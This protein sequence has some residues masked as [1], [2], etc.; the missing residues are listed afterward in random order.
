MTRKRTSTSAVFLNIGSSGDSAWW[1]GLRNR[2]ESAVTA[3]TFGVE[4]SRSELTAAISRF[5]RTRRDCSFAELEYEFPDDFNR[6]DDDGRAV[7]FGMLDQ[8][9]VFWAGLSD[10]MASTLIQMN[11]ESRLHFW[12]THFIVYFADGRVPNLPLAKNIPTAGYKQERWLPVVIKPGPFPAR[13]KGKPQQKVRRGSV[14][15][16]LPASLR[17]QIFE[18]D[19]EQC[20]YC[21]SLTGPFEIDH[22]HPVSRGGTNTPS[23]LVVACRECNRSKR[24]KLVDE[25]LQPATIEEDCS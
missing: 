17:A 23:N 2:E 1:A 15:Q 20:Q 8:N 5:I 14:R 9:V 3:T 25:W 21:D 16:S 18:R 6:R 22:I 11:D 19:G 4:H 7:S 12:P 24:D 13:P 10:R